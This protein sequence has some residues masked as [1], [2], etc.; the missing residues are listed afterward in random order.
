MTELQRQNYD[1][2]VACCLINQKTKNIDFYDKLNEE[3][4]E[5]HLAFMR[6]L[7]NKKVTDQ[8]HLASELADLKNVINN[9]LIFMEYDPEQVMKECLERQL[10]RIEK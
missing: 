3:I 9:W 5:V 1:A 8:N 7:S 10:K 6:L 4:E 2:I